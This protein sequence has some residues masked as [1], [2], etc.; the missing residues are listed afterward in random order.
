MDLNGF[1]VAAAVF[2][3]AITPFSLALGQQQAGFAELDIDKR[4]VKVAIAACD[5]AQ[6][7]PCTKYLNPTVQYNPADY[8][9]SVIAR[10]GPTPRF[11]PMSG[12][13]LGGCRSATSFCDQLFGHLVSFREL[14]TEETIGLFDRTE[15]CHDPR[16]KCGV[17][18]EIS[19]AK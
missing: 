12:C 13:E 7:T 15:Y 2:L 4:V 19:C 6:A 10:A 1:A 5:V 8:P 17:I 16:G 14:I 3:L 11:I 18:V 9:Q